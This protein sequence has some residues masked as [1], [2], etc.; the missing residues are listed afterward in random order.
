M[1]RRAAEADAFRK[2]AESIYGIRLNDR[3]YVRDFVAESDEIHGELEAFIRGARLGEPTYSEDG[4]CEVPAE[5]RVTEVL[6]ALRSARRGDGADAQVSNA[7]FEAVLR[8][9]ERDVIRVVGAA[10]SRPD[11]PPSLPRGVAEKLGPPVG[12]AAPQGPPTIP[13]VWMRVSPQARLMA[14]RAARLD[15]MRRLAERI[16]GLRLTSQTDVLDL[17]TQ[18]D[19]ITTALETHLAGTEEAAV[20]LHDQ[21]LIAEVKLAVPGEKVVELVKEVTTR[22]GRELSPDAAQRILKTVVRRELSAVGVG[23]APG[24]YIEEHEQQ[25]RVDLPPWA[26]ETLEAEGEGRDPEFATPQGRLRAAR[27]AEL[28]AKRKLLAR[29]GELE[30]QSQVRVQDF[31]AS[32]GSL[33]LRVESVLME[34]TVVDS[35]FEA[36]AARVRVAI[37]GLR[38]WEML[39]EELRPEGGS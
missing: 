5:L 12:G 30:L 24:K 39:H 31:V 13:A 33:A 19:E 11:L 29:V 35:R 2:L 3:T 37:P 36:D 22:Q 23:V 7:E 9:H 15:A 16:A 6:E 25:A 32:H 20:Y 1:A 38:V 27:A 26:S 28:E 21:E 14:I 34:A 10:V 4:V 8:T 17:V 18:R